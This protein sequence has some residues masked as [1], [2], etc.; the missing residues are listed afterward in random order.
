M[1]KIIK[2]NH[3]S[4]SG[5]LSILWNSLSKKRKLQFFQLLFLLFLG[6][7]AEVASL[8]AIIP[9]LAILINPQEALSIPLVAWAVEVFNFD[10]HQKVYGQLMVIFSII[11]VVANIVRFFLTYMII[12]FHYGLGHDLGVGIYNNVLHDEVFIS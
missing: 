5:G 1:T 3:Q 4:I 8:G 10:V 7:M 9:F 2:N 11:V 12:K 6:G